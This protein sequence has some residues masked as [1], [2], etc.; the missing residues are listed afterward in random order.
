MRSFLFSP[1]LCGDLQDK[2]RLAWQK[3]VS[4]V[5]LAEPQPGQVQQW[6]SLGQTADR[7]Q[8]SKASTSRF[9][10]IPGLP[11]PPL[12]RPG[13]AAQWIPERL[14]IK[15]VSAASFETTKPE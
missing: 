4:S 2:P 1:S 14:D 10:T 13:I 11:S 7:R 12:L 5:R 6:S 9:L 8:S 3:A 15:A